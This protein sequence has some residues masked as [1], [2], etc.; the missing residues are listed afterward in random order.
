[1][2]TASSPSSP[3]VL[4]AAT[5]PSPALYLDVARAAA[6]YAAVVAAARPIGVR[7]ATK[8]N[9]QPALLATLAVAG[10][11]F[12]VTTRPELEALLALGV[13]GA[14]IAC[15]TPGPP[16]SLLRICRAA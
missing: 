16:A 13:A 5:P 7:Y 15:V 11:E 2:H 1:M 4:R 12:A 3:P 14:R 6:D 8:A 10:A 9:P